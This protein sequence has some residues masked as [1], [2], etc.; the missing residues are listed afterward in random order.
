[1]QSVRKIFCRALIVVC[2]VLLLSRPADSTERADAFLD[3]P[4]PAD[5]KLDTFSAPPADG[6]GPNINYPGLK[7]TSFQSGVEALG[8]LSGKK[9][10][11]PDGIQKWL[12]EHSDEN[13]GMSF[14]VAKNQ[15][16]REL[17]ERLCLTLGVVWRYDPQQDA[18]ILNFNRYQNDPRSAKELVAIV[19]GQKP[20][21][22]EQLKMETNPNGVGGHGKALDEWRIA[23]DSLLSKP[24][25]F[26]TA[27]TVRIYHENHIGEM[28]HFP[29]INL[30]TGTMRDQ[31]GRDVILVINGPI[32][33]SNKD[34]PGDI[35]YYLFSEEGRFIRG[36]VY[37]MGDRYV[38]CVVSAKA[39]DAQR[40]TIDV[41]WGSFAMNP[42]HV[43][44]KI[45]DDDLVL[46]GS[47]D[48]KGKEMNAAD[49]QTSVPMAGFGSGLWKYVVANGP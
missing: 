20:P 47:T 14:G 9:V 16:V 8:K 43:H 19:A 2:G 15:S 44:F 18:I 31:N 35:A 49:T 34:S 24:E 29:V 25:N 28:M 36:G 33:M 4:F 30:L 39:D 41:G 46:S 12:K 5:L 42:T 45:A 22:W 17:F 13:W 37:S 7:L 26:L 1:M 23:F 40:V 11:L 27:G 6:K 48:D 32:Q 21:P 10:V 38:G 3:R